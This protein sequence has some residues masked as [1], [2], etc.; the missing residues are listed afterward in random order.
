MKKKR[1]NK[2]PLNELKVAVNAEVSLTHPSEVVK[3][4]AVIYCYAIKLLLNDE[5]KTIAE[6][7]QN[8]YKVIDDYIRND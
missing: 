6:R 1:C 7:M 4:A 2:L 8:T 5:G 3:Q